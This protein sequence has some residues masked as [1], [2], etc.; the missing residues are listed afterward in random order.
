MEFIMSNFYDYQW[1]WDRDRL[2]N[3]LRNDPVMYLSPETVDL[4]A[5]TVNDIARDKILA[6]IINAK[7][8][9][10][11][12]DTMYPGN[13]E[14]YLNDPQ[15]VFRLGTWPIPNLAI[16]IRATNDNEATRRLP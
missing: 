15:T 1:R 12:V 6:T 5:L 2:F 10:F 11:M 16:G 7:S 4:F 3:S 9:R 8:Y 13:M 14:R